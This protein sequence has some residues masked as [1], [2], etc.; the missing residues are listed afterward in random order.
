MEN[1][2]PF[3]NCTITVHLEINC[4]HR[5]PVVRLSDALLNE[6]KQ[7][8][9][10]NWP[11]DSL[12]KKAYW[13]QGFMAAVLPKVQSRIRAYFLEKISKHVLMGESAKA[14]L[15]ARFVDKSLLMSML[16]L[17]LTSGLGCTP[18]WCYACGHMEFYFWRTRYGTHYSQW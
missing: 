3:L 13:Y 2:A 10:Q 9:W 14:Y 15:L 6:N 8:L 11:Q 1:T 12:K 18:F 5:V 7:C 4:D 17:R 16:G